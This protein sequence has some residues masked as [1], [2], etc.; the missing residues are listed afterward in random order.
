MPD[1]IQTLPPGPLDIIGD[2]HGEID[3]LRQL[4]KELGYDEEGNH[5]ND[6]LLVFVGDFC[7]R[8]PDSCYVSVQADHNLR[9]RIQFY[10][11]KS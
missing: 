3:S 11:I 2:I 4:L 7:D 1:L 10:P 9:S 8:G 6:R 5:P